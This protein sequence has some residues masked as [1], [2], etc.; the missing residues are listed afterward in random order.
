MRWAVVQGA[1]R[2]LRP[3]SILEIGCGQGAFGA[4]L[5]RDYSYLGLEP[6]AESFTTARARIEMAGGRIRSESW[7]NVG[8]ETFDLVCAF[9]VLEHIEDDRGAL[10]A[11][12]A[13]VR[14]GGHLMISVPA[15]PKRYNA[16]DAMVGHY[17]RYSPD[18]CEAL[19]TDVGLGDVRTELY[20]WPLGFAT[21]RIRGVIAQRRTRSTANATEAKTIEERTAA[22][23]RVLQPKHRIGSVAELATAP[24]IQI[25]RLQ[26][27]KGTG[28][29]AWGRRPP[30]E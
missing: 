5:A 26:P 23:G 10:A 3:A 8:A 18:A 2:Q 20:G 11:W 29:V 13:L 9:E 22:S 1:I 19:L 24:F 21:E 7:D 6:D 30:A 27:A 12:S 25:Q 15:W 28:L 4:R 17:R 14:P 16:W